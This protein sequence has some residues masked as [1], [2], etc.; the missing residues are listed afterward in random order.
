MKFSLISAIDNTAVKTYSEAVQQCPIKINS[1][2]IDG[3]YDNQFTMDSVV[4][5]TSQTM[6]KTVFPQNASVDSEHKG[7]FPRR[8]LAKGIPVRVTNREVIG[9]KQTEEKSQPTSKINGLS[10]VRGSKAS[11]RNTDH[12]RL[13]IKPHQS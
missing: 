13:H 12:R 5:D 8:S 1:S 10:S 7:R 4:M 3:G 11:K 2:S 9:D 6:P